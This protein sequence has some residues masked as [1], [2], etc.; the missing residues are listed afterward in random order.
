MEKYTKLDKDDVVRRY[1]N[2]PI[3]LRLHRR[4]D[5]PPEPWTCISW[6]TRY[7]TA[8][9]QNRRFYYTNA[10]GYWA[11]PTSLALDML[12][13][14]EEKEMLDER[15]DDPQT[16]HGGT[17]NE[18]IDSRELNLQDRRNALDS[19]TTENETGDWSL[20]SVFTIIEVPDGSWRKVMIVDI[21]RGL[22]TFRSTT[23]DTLYK[24]II[25]DGMTYPWLMDNAM[26]DASTAMMREF[27]R[28]LREL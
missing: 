4:S 19:I 2:L 12:E 6:R 8:P 21:E 18:I 11:T 14:A 26:Q 10:N 5:V 27:L 23:T 24:P 7:S 15:Y 28:V 13:E 1:G 3:H 25:R 9:N 16:R 22:C 17:D 20:D